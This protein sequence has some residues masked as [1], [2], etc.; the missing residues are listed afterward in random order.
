MVFLGRSVKLKES[1]MKI[2]NGILDI[3]W[4]YL[5]ALMNQLEHRFGA[6]EAVQ[7]FVRSIEVFFV[8][9]R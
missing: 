8:Q 3:V 9:Y 7:S 5:R 2:S 4:A 6:I 1:K